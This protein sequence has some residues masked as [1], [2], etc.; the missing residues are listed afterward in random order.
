MTALAI[1]RAAI[2]DM[3]VST[4]MMKSAFQSWNQAVNPVAAVAAGLIHA[5][6]M[7][8]KAFAN[9][10][11]VLT[12]MEKHWFFLDIRHFDYFWHINREGG[13]RSK[14]KNTEQ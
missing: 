1:G 13:N 9:R 4:L 3:T 10:G 2:F 11:L 7:A 12:V 5:G 6:V 14:R 8:I